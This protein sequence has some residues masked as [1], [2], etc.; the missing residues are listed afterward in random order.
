MIAVA[1]SFFLYIYIVV[2]ELYCYNY[3]LFIQ[4][5]WQKKNSYTLVS[6]FI[7]TLADKYYEAMRVY[8]R[9]GLSNIEDAILSS[10]S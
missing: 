4:Y 5:Y 7:Y 8:T 1:R 2:W 6:S 9:C 3:N 10:R